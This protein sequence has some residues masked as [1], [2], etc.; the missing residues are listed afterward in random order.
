MNAPN[1]AIG[2][3][4]QQ[5]LLP[6]HQAPTST[7]IVSSCICSSSLPPCGTALPTHDAPGANIHVHLVQLQHVR[8]HLSHRLGLVV[9]LIRLPGVLQLGLGEPGRRDQGG[10]GSQGRGAG[11][12][13]RGGEAAPGSGSTT[14]V[15]GRAAAGAG[16]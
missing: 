7:A 10:A 12:E 5:G 2:I 13:D 15:G 11:V 16:W 9:L 6:P 1:H 8:R 3:I 14:R 4:E